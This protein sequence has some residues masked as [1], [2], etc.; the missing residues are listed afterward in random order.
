MARSNNLRPRSI[1]SKNRERNY[2]YMRRNLYAARMRMG[3]SMQEVARRVGI[4]PGY[5]SRIEN[6][7][8]E[9]SPTVMA[10]IADVLNV[11]HFG[12]LY[13]SQRVVDSR[14]NKSDTNKK[15]AQA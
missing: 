7:Q 2:K 13:Y 1:G 8:R 9:P 3:L 15:D 4:N 6:D 10:R 11:A 14:E 5:Y 12:D